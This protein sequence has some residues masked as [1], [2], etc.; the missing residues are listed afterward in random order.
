MS[1][2]SRIL[3]DG[4]VSVAGVC[5]VRCRKRQ[6]GR[7][8]VMSILEPSLVVSVNAGFDGLTRVFHKSCFA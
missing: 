6:R 8:P 1:L 2:R 7:R 5:G 3:A 4:E